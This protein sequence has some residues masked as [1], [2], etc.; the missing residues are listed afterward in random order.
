[1]SGPPHLSHSSLAEHFCELVGAD[2]AGAGQGSRQ[3]VHTPRRQVRQSGS[4]HHGQHQPRE[5]LETPLPHLL[6]VS[7][8]HLQ[9]RGI[10]ANEEPHDVEAGGDRCPQEV[11]A[12]AEGDH[13]REED[14][15]QCRPGHPEQKIALHAQRRPV[16][17]LR[18]QDRPDGNLVQEGHDRKP[19]GRE[20]PEA[21][22]TDDDEAEPDQ[23]DACP[24]VDADVLLLLGG[25]QEMRREHDDADQGEDPRDPPEATVTVPLH[26]GHQTAKAR[27]SRVIQ[28]WIGRPACA[29]FLDVAVGH[30]PLLFSVTPVSRSPAPDSKLV[31]RPVLS[32]PPPRS[33]HWARSV[34]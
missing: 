28:A 25:Q 19:L 4:D 9:G 10:G 11:L 26:L 29:S 32:P 17:E 7:P 24:Q 15:P 16:E 22:R 18:R 2:L 21:A 8:S 33:M 5:H 20:V 3:S 30:F 31:W 13:V 1:M 14:H 27:A 23:R 34:P 6:S 12:R